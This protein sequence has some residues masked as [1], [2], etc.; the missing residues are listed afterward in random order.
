MF[1]KTKNYKQKFGDGGFTLVEIMVSVSIFVSVAL[2][3]TSA[4]ITTSETNRKAQAIK[5]AIDN[6]SFA[7]DS[8]SLKIRQGNTFRCL[9][10]GTDPAVNGDIDT[11]E[12]AENCE[13]NQDG[14]GLAFLEPD[15]DK[16]IYLF[17]DIAEKITYCNPSNG[18]TCDEVDITDTGL[19][20]ITDMQ[21]YVWNAESDSANP[22]RAKGKPRIAIAL[23]GKTKD[24]K[25]ATE[26][27]LQTT[28]SGK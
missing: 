7:L 19:I 25:L 3:V 24:P 21:F 27:Y 20:N 26:F 22:P 23:S 8:M 12:S 4:V 28:V 14:N 5:V 10:S 17:D 11:P 18:A 6:L 13:I 16:V 2:L 9:F 15:G 1:L